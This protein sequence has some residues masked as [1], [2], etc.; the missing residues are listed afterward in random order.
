MANEQKEIQKQINTENNAN[1]IRNAADVAIATKHPIGVAAG[2]AV[3]VADK[4]TGGKSSEKLGRKITRTNQFAPGGKRIQNLSNRLSE[5][6]ASDAIGK[7]ASAKSG[8]AGS[9]SFLGSSSGNGGMIGSHSTL[10]DDDSFGNADEKSKVKISWKKVPLKIKLI[11]IAIGAGVVLIFFFLLMIV[12]PLISLGIIKGGGRTGYTMGYSDIFSGISYWWPV[13]SSE[14]EVIDG[15]TFAGGTPVSTAISSYFGPREAPIEGASTNHGA[16]DIP[17]PVG[18]NV[19]APMAGRILSVNTDPYANSC[20]VYVSM[21]VNG[22][23]L[24]FCHLSGVNVSVND[25]VDQGQVIAFSGN[26]GLSTGPH[27]HFAIRV[28]GTLEDPLNYVSADNPRPT[29]ITSLYDLPGGYG[30]SEEN[31]SAMCSILLSEG[32]TEDAVAGVLVNVAHEGSFLTNNM[33]NCYESGQCCKVGGKNYGLCTKDSNDPLRNYASDHLY[34]LAVDNGSYSK[35]N[36]ISDGVGYGLIQ[37]TS[38][39]RKSNLYDLAKRNNASIADLGVQVSHL[40]NEITSGSYIPT[41][42]ALTDSSKTAYEVA[43][44]F[45]TDF[46]RPAGGKEACEARASSSANKYLSYV[47]NGCK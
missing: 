47:R 30:S 16:I 29:E 27:L 23:Y 42:D 9:K 12:A 35:N 5:S 4:V 26:T 7:A 6:G 34:T 10:G 19:I 22:N 28:N 17:V 13:G 1:N 14:T 41:M 21:D 37:W 38:S 20:G 31:K 3:K 25:V 11:F 43:T 18:T 46:E 24:L 45:C 40:F 36:F 8:M 32:Y 33:E 2:T 15:K 44:T 39:G